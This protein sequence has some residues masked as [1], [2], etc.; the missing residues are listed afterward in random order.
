MSYQLTVDG[1]VREFELYLPAGWEYWLEELYAADNSRDG[2]PLLVMLHR[3][4]QHPADFL[5]DWPFHELLDADAVLDNKFFVLVPYGLSFYGPDESTTR[6]WNVWPGMWLPEVDDIAF[7]RAA[8]DEVRDMLLAAL[9]VIGSDRQPIDRN[10][11]HLFGYSDGAMMAYKAV[12]AIPNFFASLWVMSG[13]I[14]GMSD[15]LITAVT[16]TNAP[17]PPAGGGAPIGVSLFIHHGELDVTVPPGAVGDPVTLVLSQ[18][19]YDELVDAS[20][21]PLRAFMY[22]IY[23]RS[24]Q[25]AFDEYEAYNLSAG[26]AVPYTLV[27]PGQP[28]GAGTFLSTLTTIGVGLP[29]VHEYRDPTMTHDNYHDPGRVQYK[30]TADVWAWFKIHPKA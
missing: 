22:A 12:S 9:A 28:D 10:R 6:G 13:A 7:L 25:A 27:V 29:Q 18:T 8:Y 20:F 23:Y 5:T 21:N 24:V 4:A 17:V 1:V 16:T 15:N 30:T 14:G 2:L 26:A 19:S 3:G 11:V